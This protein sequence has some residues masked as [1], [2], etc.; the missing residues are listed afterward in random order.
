MYLPAGITVPSSAKAPHTEQYLSPVYPF[1][2]KVAAVAFFNSPLVSCAASLPWTAHP[3]SLQG[4][5]WVLLSYSHVEVSKSCSVT[6]NLTVAVASALDPPYLEY[7][8]VPLNFIVA[9]Y[10][11]T[12]KP[13]FGFMLQLEVFSAPAPT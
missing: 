3:V 7:S 5:Q 12:G 1:V 2:S 10:V 8:G 9:T 6:T 11:P 4:F 13:L